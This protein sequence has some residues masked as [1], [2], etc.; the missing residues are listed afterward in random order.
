MQVV[1][2]NVVANNRDCIVVTPGRSRH[3]ALTDFR[4]S[5][6]SVTRTEIKKISVE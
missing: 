4:M 2:S 5:K 6:E 3:A 1:V